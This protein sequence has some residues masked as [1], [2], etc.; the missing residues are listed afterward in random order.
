V[1]PHDLLAGIGILV[2]LVSVVIVVL[3]GLLIVVGSVVVWAL[4]EQSVAGWVVMALAVGLGAAV[5]VLKY[6]HPGRQLRET[7]IPTIGLLIA[8]GVAVAGFF[9]IPVVGAFIGF[10]VA[11]YVLERIRVG[12]Q[13]ARA[14][15]AATL[16]AIA[17]S[18]GIELAG[19]F[20][21]AALWL[22]AVIWG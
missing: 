5:T 4:L 2:G 19:C 10:V 16:K 11:V 14:S 6:L 7:G 12:P 21:I 15:T 17:L 8:L 20:V 3:P 22:A 9:L 18:I 1:Q 13:G